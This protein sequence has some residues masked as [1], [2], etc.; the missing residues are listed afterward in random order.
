[1]FGIAALSQV[2]FSSL[3]GGSLFA[4]DISENTGVADTPVAPFAFLTSLAEHIN[5]TDAESTGSLYIFALNEASSNA[6]QN[7]QQSAFF[8]SIAEN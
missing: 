4:F 7:A 6:D 3:A 8:H 5:V 2:P 1:M